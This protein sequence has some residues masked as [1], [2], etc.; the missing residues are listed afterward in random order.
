MKLGELLNSF[1]RPRRRLTMTHN[2]QLEFPFC[3]KI[4]V[5]SHLPK[6]KRREVMLEKSKASTLISRKNFAP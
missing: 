4:N 1:Q 6:K 2:L 3:G 5:I